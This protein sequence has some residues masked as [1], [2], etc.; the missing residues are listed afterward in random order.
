MNA[1]E[2]EPFKA[3]VRE[4]FGLA[5]EPQTQ[6]K[7]ASALTRRMVAC[8]L[9]LP[10]A[11]AARLRSDTTEQQALVN[12]LT[13]NETYFFREP[14]QLRLLVE[15][16]IPRRMAA[17]ESEAPVRI[18]SAGCSSGEEVYSVI[19]LLTELHGELTTE[20]FEV[21]GGD[22]D[23]AM[24]EKARVGCYGRFSFRGVS[25]ERQTRFFMPHEG[26]F[27]V[28][29]AIRQQARF[30]PLNLSTPSASLGLFDAILYRNVSIYFDEPTR[31]RILRNLVRLL[32]PE[33]YLLIGATETL[34]NDMGVL[35]LIQEDGVFYFTHR[36]PDGAVAA[37]IPRP[38]P[39]PPIQKGPRATSRPTPRP[40]S[41]KPPPKPPQTPLDLESIQALIGEQRFGDALAALE[42]R[43]ARTPAESDARLLRAYV[44]LERRQFDAAEA[45]V[46]AV[47]EQAPWLTDAWLLLGLA[48]KWHDQSDPALTA[49]KR[50]IYIQP[51]CWPAHF[52]LGELYRAQGDR[53]L[54]TRAW[55]AVTRLLASEPW[56][57][58][59]LRLRVLEPPPKMARYLCQQYLKN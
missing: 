57:A 14:E 10:S 33:G 27:E 55:R 44:L 42:T 38:E 12:L 34:G 15:C 39:P 56:P 35:E 40:A 24:L 41:P 36:R 20:Y 28:K 9:H 3:L 7:L 2:L 16:L 51:D 26:Q 21:I 5:F 25:L 18:L 58:S 22:I 53:P 45:E 4:Q 31:E 50:V 52:H 23:S 30:V 46:R 47:I 6:H 1:E 29:A 54:A 11:Y 8:N 19:M 13:V 49:F 32:K 48:A 37:L 17:R 59:G 43:L